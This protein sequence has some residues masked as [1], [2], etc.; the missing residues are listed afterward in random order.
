[1]EN[2]L[3]IP[4]EITGLDAIPV[5]DIIAGYNDVMDSQFSENTDANNLT[6]VQRLTI[7][8]VIKR[9]ADQMSEIFSNQENE[10]EMWSYDDFDNAYNHGISFQEK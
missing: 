3:E 9:N 2:K 5:S 7:E 4:K 10:M 8:D 1:M 6:L